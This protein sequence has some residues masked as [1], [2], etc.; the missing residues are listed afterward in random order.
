MIE[1]VLD[2]HYKSLWVVK[3]Y[4]GHGNAIQL[5]LENEMKRIIP[6]LMIV[7]ERLNLFIQAQ[8][9][10]SIAELLVEEEETHRFG[11]GAF[12]EEF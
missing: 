7:F 4:V 12:M 11:V 2:P 3:N 9:V 6:L 5:A 10:V 1:S 8:V